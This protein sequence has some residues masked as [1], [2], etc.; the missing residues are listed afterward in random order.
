M[1]DIALSFT[2]E[3]ITD[4]FHH[5]LAQTDSFLTGD[6]KV[7]L[8]TDFTLLH[9]LRRKSRELYSD[10]MFSKAT[11]YTASVVSTL[12][13]LNK[14]TLVLSTTPLMASVFRHL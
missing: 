1:E 5:S 10:T 9:Y 6:T 4:A 7:P 2:L 8:L 14:R 3:E 13:K 11:Q 12:A